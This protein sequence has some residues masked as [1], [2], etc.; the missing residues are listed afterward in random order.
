MT[1]HECEYFFEE[2]GT[3]RAVIEIHKT[4]EGTYKVYD[5]DAME[6]WATTYD[7]LGKAI[8][9]VKSC[10]MSDNLIF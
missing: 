1:K 3:S 6:Y 5:V 10:T 9:A 4:S 8:D 2:K 7:S